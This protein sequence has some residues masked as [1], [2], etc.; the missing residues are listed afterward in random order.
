VRTNGT[1]ISTLVRPISLRTRFRRG[2]PSRSSRGSFADVA[3]GAAEAQHRVFFFRLVELAADQ[4][5]YSLDLKS[6]RRT[7]TGFG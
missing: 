4:L 5:A 6:D 7:M 1:M 2:I 3:R